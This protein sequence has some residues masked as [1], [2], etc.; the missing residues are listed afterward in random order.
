MKRKYY[1]IPKIFVAK[2]GLTDQLREFPDG[3]YLCTEVVMARIHADINRALDITG[4]CEITLD[5]ARDE[6]LG[7]IVTRLPGD[8]EPEDPNAPLYSDGDD[9][10]A[11]EEGGEA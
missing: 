6:Q 7:L 1:K 2:L 8:R 10:Q 9:S 11:N 4:G 3:R 5:Q